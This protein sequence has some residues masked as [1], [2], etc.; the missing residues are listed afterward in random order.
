VFYNIK[1]YNK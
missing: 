1:L